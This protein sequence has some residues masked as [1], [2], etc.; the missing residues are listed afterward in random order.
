[1]NTRQCTSTF[2]GTPC[3]APDGHHGDHTHTHTSGHQTTWDDLAADKPWPYTSYP[4][5]R[6]QA[7]GQ[8]FTAHL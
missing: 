7:P 5:T 3:Q 2:L 4:A 6:G 8:N 1:M